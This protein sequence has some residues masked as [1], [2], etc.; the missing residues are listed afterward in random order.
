MTTFNLTIRLGNDA[1]SDAPP[2]AEALRSVAAIL[3]E[4]YVGCDP[5]EPTSPGEYGT[6]IR[7]ANGNRVGEWS[8]TEDAPTL[9]PEQTASA[10]ELA[11]RFMEAAEGDSGDAEFSAAWALADYVLSAARIVVEREAAD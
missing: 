11:D 7:D 10:A 3:D 6:I 9:T 4:S 8:V 5:I 1:M 2:I